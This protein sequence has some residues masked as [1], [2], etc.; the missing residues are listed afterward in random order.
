MMVLTFQRERLRTI[1][2][3]KLLETALFAV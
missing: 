2:V 1:R 3:K